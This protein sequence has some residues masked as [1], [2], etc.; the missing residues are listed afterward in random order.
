MN[1]ALSS[2]L[3]ALIKWNRAK[4]I[5][6]QRSSY[7]IY[8]Y[9]GINYSLIFAPNW[10]ASTW[11]RQNSIFKTFQRKFKFKLKFFFFLFKNRDV[12]R[13]HLTPKVFKRNVTSYKNSWFSFLFFFVVP[14]QLS[15]V[16]CYFNPIYVALKF[17]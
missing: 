13:P 6:R 17:S 14:L 3:D 8:F 16:P 10:F 1:F 15:R 5:I 12:P 2:D 11:N 9:S 4:L 7:S